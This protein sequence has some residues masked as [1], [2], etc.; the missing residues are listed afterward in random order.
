MA[1]IQISAG[2]IGL[3]SSLCIHRRPRNRCHFQAVH[4]SR[5]P[6]IGAEQIKALK[7]P[8]DKAT[9][10]NEYESEPTSS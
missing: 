10:L 2:Y 6:T 4:E 1:K 9:N 5:Q 7:S 8:D 3:V